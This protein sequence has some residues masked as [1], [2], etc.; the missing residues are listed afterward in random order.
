M[1]LDDILK[2]LRE[3]LRL[4]DSRIAFLSAL[5]IESEPEHRHRSRSCRLP[6]SMA[7]LSARPKTALRQSQ[8]GSKKDSSHGGVRS[9]LDRANEKVV[10]CHVVRER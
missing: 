4:I 3:E 6:D 1:N 10:C 9:A 2:D 8:F 7:G 5:A